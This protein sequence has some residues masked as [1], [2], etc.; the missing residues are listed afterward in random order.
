MRLAIIS[1]K[2]CWRVSDSPSQYSTDGGFPI[3]VGA[4]SELFDK[5]VVVLPVSADVRCQG[6]QPITGKNVSIRQLSAPAGKGAVRKLL[7]PFWLLANGPV[8]WKEVGN[9]DAVHAPIPGDIGTVG[10]LFAL[11][12]RKPLFVRYCGNWLV[13]R[14]PTERFW[15]WLM[16]RFAGGHNVMLATGGTPDP[17][18]SKNPN[19]KW[20]FSTSLRQKQLDAGEVRRLPTDGALRLIIACRQEDRKG[21]DVVIKSLPSIMEVFPNSTLDVVGGGSRL[22]ELKNL[23]NTIGVQHNVHFHG[24]IDHSS[25]IGL[26]EQAHIFCFPT[27]SEGFPKVVIEALA[28]GLPVIT[29][30]VSVLPQLIKNGSGKLLAEATPSELAKSVKEICSDGNRYRTMSARAIETAREYSL[31]NWRDSIGEKLRQA[32]N[33]SALSSR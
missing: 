11:M 26:M 9:S 12:Q 29:T 22:S 23:A 16:E 6:V 8:I 17:P 20:L 24:Q 25:V 27:E 31:E 33:V 1:H 2:V 10:L 7:I 3:Q 5:T 21:T 30:Q 14:T 18:S 32:W 4:L 15:R 13:Q 19:I 28:C